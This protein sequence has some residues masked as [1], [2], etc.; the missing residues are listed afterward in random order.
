[1]TGKKENDGQS[2]QDALKQQRILLREQLSAQRRVYMQKL[3]PISSATDE[4]TYPRSRTMRLLNEHPDLARKLLGQAALLT[5]GGP[6]L[7]SLFSG[8]ALARLLRGRV[9]S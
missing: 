5:L 1:M 4:S 6:V 8:M 2:V 9:K 3:M 7:K